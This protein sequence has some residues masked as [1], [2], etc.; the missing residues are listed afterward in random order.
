M[1]SIYAA[2]VIGAVTATGSFVAFGKLQ[3]PGKGLQPE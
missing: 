2:N 3:V 1:S